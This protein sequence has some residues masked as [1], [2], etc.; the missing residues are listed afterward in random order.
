MIDAFACPEVN[1][2]ATEGT[3]RESLV[4]LKKESAWRR[5]VWWRGLQHKYEHDE[6]ARRSEDSVK[7]SSRNLAVLL[8]LKG[9]KKS[10]RFRIVKALELILAAAKIF[11]AARAVSAGGRAKKILAHA[12][13]KKRQLADRLSALGN[14]RLS[15]SS[16]IEGEEQVRHVVVP[17]GELLKQIAAAG[18][19]ALPLSDGS[20]EMLK[21]A[22]E[23]AGEGS[24][25]FSTLCLM[26]GGVRRVTTMQ[27]LS[28]GDDEEFSTEP[29]FTEMYLG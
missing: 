19:G 20:L 9:V 23:E 6:D 24:I 28:M 21:T 25:S 5:R 18:P 4:H 15:L 27:G 22:L 29:S 17:I 14:R 7:L 13:N 11:E 26:L 2:M 1:R 3:K 8:G 12:T 16:S 10:H